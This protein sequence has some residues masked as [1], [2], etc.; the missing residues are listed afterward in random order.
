LA[1]GGVYLSGVGL[2][3][4]APGE[5]PRGLR[6]GTQEVT[7]RGFGPGGMREIAVLMRR[8]LIDR[9]DPLKVLQDTV[10]LRRSIP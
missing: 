10:A 7:R 6:I 5:P 8:L 4:Q 3:G 1:E 2:P 9:Q